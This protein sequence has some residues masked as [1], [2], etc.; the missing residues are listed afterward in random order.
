MR[1]SPAVWI[2]SPDAKA[3]AAEK[4]KQQL[5]AYRTTVT[6]PRPIRAAVL[7]AAGQDTV[8]AWIDGTP[9]L[10]AAP[11]PPWQQMPWKKFVRADVTGKLTQ[12][13]NTLAIECVHYVVNPNGMAAEDDPPTI[14]TLA[15]EYADG[16][17]ATFS[18]N[19]KW[20][21]SIHA[22]AGWQ[23]PGFNDSG[24]KNCNRLYARSP[25]RRQTPLG[26]PWIPDSV[27]SLR[28]T[29][30]T[31][32]VKSARLYAT[33]LGAYE[34]FL[35][36][37]RVGDDV[38]APGWTDYRNHVNYQTYDVTAQIVA[39]NNAIAALLAP[40]WY[41]LAARVVPAA[42]QLRRNAARPA[43]PVAHRAHRRLRPVGKHRRNLA[44]RS[45]LHS[46]LGNLRRRNPGRAP[47][48]TRLETRQLHGQKLVPRSPHPPALDRH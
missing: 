4:G 45:L 24:W 35:N 9:V 30:Q 22:P 23:K 46:A 41:A 39:G 20:K 47:S 14:A 42:Q 7:F 12:G 19:P 18:T 10:T 16:T 44:R 38:L 36:G 13:V 15:V 48:A 40:G 31:S 17:W 1:T 8:S 27:K 43:R 6:L 5:F 37:K 29:F 3:L 2:A 28:H 21:T 34:L 32:A 33:A 11:L 26:H 25:A